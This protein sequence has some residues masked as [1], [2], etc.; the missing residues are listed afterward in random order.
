MVCF[1]A[2]HRLL[3][4]LTALRE[5]I[6]PKREV[7]VAREMTKVHEQVITGNA[8]EVLAYYTTHPEKV[9]GEVVLVISSLRKQ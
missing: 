1:E 6:N 3:K 7:I 4:T 5:H 2:P 9:R 8:E